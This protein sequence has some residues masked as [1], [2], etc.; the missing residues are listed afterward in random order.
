[1]TSDSSFEIFSIKEVKSTDKHFELPTSNYNLHR[2]NNKAVMRVRLNPILK[3]LFTKQQ[4][5]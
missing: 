3:K 5:I 2:V 4:M 1:M